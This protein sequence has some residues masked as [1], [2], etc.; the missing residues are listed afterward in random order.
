MAASLTPTAFAALLKQIYPEGVPYDLAMKNHPRMSMLEKMDDFEG[1]TIEIPIY[2]ENPMGRSATFAN[3]QANTNPSQSVKWTLP[4]K[5]DH[6]IITIDALTIR[7]SRSNVGSF[8]RARQTEI[9][10]L[11]Q[12]LGNSAAHSLY[13]TAGGSIGRIAVLPAGANPTITLTSREDTRFFAVGMTVVFGP[14]ED[15]TLL[16][17]GGVG[18]GFVAVVAAVN[19]SAGTVT[20]TF[21]PDITIVITDF[22]FVQ[23]DA[24]L[25]MNGVADYNPLTS[26]TATPFLGVNRSVQPTRL[27][28]QRRNTPLTSIKENVLRLTEEIVRQGGNPDYTFISHTKFSDLVTDLGGQVRFQG[29]GGSVDWGWS[30]VEIHTS[31]GTVKVVAD[32]DDPEDRIYVQDLGTWQLHTLDGFPHIDTLDGN[33]SLRQ[34]AADGIEVRARYWANQTCIAPGRN[35]V[36][37]I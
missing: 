26:P 14:Q 28:G 9:D 4:I 3:A 18:A 7:K 13:R 34:A 36:A 29:A 19:E 24:T 31:G 30:Y 32:A 16:R 2:F 5:E 23:G 27:G 12:Q 10:M 6:G 22:I 11:L 37:S 17:N 33:N 1:S 15:G 8:V 20:L 25:K 21:A 35:G